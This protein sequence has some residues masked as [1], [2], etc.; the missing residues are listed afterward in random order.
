M[1]RVILSDEFLEKYDKFNK[2]YLKIM[3]PVLL[4][5]FILA[6]LVTTYILNK[7]SDDQK[8][9]E[10][11]LHDFYEIAR[12]AADIQN[13]LT[14]TIYYT[15]PYDKRSVPWT[16][17]QLIEAVDAYGLVITDPNRQLRQDQN[18]F[19]IDIDYTNI[20]DYISEEDCRSLLQQVSPEI[21]E[22]VEESADIE[23]NIDAHIYYVFKYYNNP[24][25][26]VAMCSYGKDGVHEWDDRCMNIYVFGI[27]VKADKAFYDII[28]PFLPERF[29]DQLEQY[30]TGTLPDNN[31]DVLDT[32]DTQN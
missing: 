18:M 3:V 25:L 32:P 22:V 5:A 13:D 11:M 27:E 9:L 1:K 23:E 26:E 29:A 28:I 7:Y 24:Y 12:T 6:V 17:D 21:I 2:A 19:R 16:V 31:V 10:A 14:L 4:V 15:S 8:Y 20:K 30:I